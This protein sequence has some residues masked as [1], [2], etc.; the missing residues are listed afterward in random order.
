MKI[1][2]DVGH[3]GLDPGAVGNYDGYT[4]IERDLNLVQANILREML[5]GYE[6]VEVLQSRLTNDL[7]APNDADG[8]NGSSYRCNLWGT[9]VYGAPV[10]LMVS[11][12]NNAATGTARGYDVIHSISQ[13]ADLAEFIGSEYE[14]I[15]RP[16]HAI[17]TRIGAG[18]LDYYG[19]I[20]QTVNEQ[21]RSIIIESVFI[22]NPG[23]V[24]A[25]IWDEDTGAYRMDQITRLMRA[26]CDGIVKFYGLKAKLGANVPII[27]D[28]KIEPKPIKPFS[29]S[30]V[31]VAF[32]RIEGDKAVIEI[33][34]NGHIRMIDV[35]TD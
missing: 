27:E 14:T 16:K 18:G 1:Y 35:P 29:I 12:H 11:V 21:T 26:V 17:F 20:R 2:I 10:D 32:D 3:S 7:S 25:W 15:G 5:L 9:D 19:I 13:S 22:D 33:V 28:G 34:I 6:G 30:S 23:E 24:K 4:I 8:I 31:N